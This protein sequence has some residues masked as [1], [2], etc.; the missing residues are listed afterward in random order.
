MGVA[1]V[2]LP[3]PEHIAL[4]DAPVP[5]AQPGQVL[6]RNRFFQVSRPVAHA[7]VRRDRGHAAAR[8]APGDS[9]PSAAIVEVVTAPDDSG[10]NP[11]ELVSHRLGWREQVIAGCLVI[12]P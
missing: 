1:P 7:A 2:G 10:L 11:D 4:V 12:A 6:V 8:E 3:R 9:L 5:V